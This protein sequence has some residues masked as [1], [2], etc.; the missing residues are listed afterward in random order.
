MA[1]AAGTNRSEL[2]QLA[3]DEPDAL[4][5]LAEKA[6]PE[7]ADYLARVLEEEGGG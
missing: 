7:L 4:R 1:E 3:R 2:R 6:E 5:S